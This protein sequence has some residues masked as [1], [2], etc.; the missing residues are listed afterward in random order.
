MLRSIDRRTLTITLAYY[1]AFLVVGAARGLIGP[2]LVGLAAQTHSQLGQV[3]FILATLNLG[4]LLSNWQTGKLYDRVPGHPVI[5]AGLAGAGLLLAGVPWIPQL[6]LLAIMVLLAGFAI[7]CVETGVNTLMSWVHERKVGPYMTAMYLVGGLG[8]VLSPFFLAQSILYSGGIQW[9]WWLLA[10]MV[11]PGI[12]LLAGQPSPPHPAPA[13]TV[14]NSRSNT[15]VLLA[16]MGMYFLYVGAH[17]SFNS[18]L[19]PYVVTLDLA[20][21]V[22][23]AYLSS[24]FW[25]VLTLGRLLTIWLITRFRTGDIL[26]A[27]LAGGVASMLVILLWPHSLAAVWVGTLGFGLAIA[28][29]MPAG[30]VF[31]SQN[32]SITGR[33]T[34]WFMAS[35]SVGAT[36]M[37]WL[38]GLVFESAGPPAVMLSITLSLSL[39]LALFLSYALTARQR[40]TSYKETH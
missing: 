17:S 21:E 13:P 15:L 19:Y 5:L 9:G 20:D 32:M 26:I 12:L 16:I 36:L 23:A 10:A 38:N 4:N 31:A 18:W 27:E 3:S 33:A 24:A 6:P 22:H 39:S 37:P 30:M 34:G 1:A 8:A 28:G 2:S 29:I 35:A 7:G 40:A 14:E 11:L 25:L